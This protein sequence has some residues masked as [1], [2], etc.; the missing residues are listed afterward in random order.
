[1]TYSLSHVLH[2]AG[3]I[4]QIIERELRSRESSAVRVMR[5]NALLLKAQRRLARI[6]VSDQPALQLAAV[7]RRRPAAR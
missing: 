3:R 2:R 5:L 7:S 1:M 6:V 4:R